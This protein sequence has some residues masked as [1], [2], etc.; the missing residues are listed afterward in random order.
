MNINNSDINKL[1]N[2][3]LQDLNKTN[4]ESCNI[5]KLSINKYS[6]I[7][8]SCKHKYHTDCLLNSMK[9]N[10]ECPYCRTHI[11]INSYKDQCCKHL[12]TGCQ[13]KK[14]VYND[15]KL[16]I[17]HIKMMQKN[18][19]NDD[20]KIKNIITRKRN[21]IYKLQEDINKLKKQLSQNVNS[22]I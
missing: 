17:T 6:I 22:I 13:C 21:Q 8:L 7:T 3:V 5:C 20:E 9:K 14:K 11:N 12:K 2:E 1:Y 18:I 19:T 15:E 10:K 4:N 16:C